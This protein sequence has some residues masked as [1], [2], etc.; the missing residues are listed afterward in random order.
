M[1]RS[2]AHACLPVCVLS[3]L[4]CRGAVW[5]AVL[6]RCFSFLSP[7]PPPLP[8]RLLSRPLLAPL[9]TTC[10]PW[11]DGPPSLS[12]RHAVPKPARRRRCAA[13]AAP[14]RLPCARKFVHA[15][16]CTLTPLLCRLFSPVRV[17]Q[18][19]CMRA[20]MPAPCRSAR[21]LRRPVRRR[22]M[23]H[24]TRARRYPTGS[25]DAHRALSSAHGDLLHLFFV[26]CVHSV[27]P[28]RTRRTLC[29]IKR[30]VHLWLTARSGASC[31]FFRVYS[32]LRRAIWP[33]RQVRPCWNGAL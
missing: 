31:P 18:A 26:C 2:I 5:S 19:L 21:M 15:R 7:C 10:C 11:R 14:D 17:L 30:R 6:R 20:R 9:T 4:C 23:R 8:L 29:T 1:A 32:F 25:A 28:A 27:Q 12:V 33:H 22:D 3:P 13:R 16:D 24:T